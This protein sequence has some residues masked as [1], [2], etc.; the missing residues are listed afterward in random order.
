MITYPPG[1]TP[2]DP[3][4]E[5][6]LFVD[7]VTMAEL[8]EAEQ[9]NIL[10]G[11]RWALSSPRFAAQLLSERGLRELHKRMFGDVWR[12]AGSFRTRDLNL[13]VEWAR[14]AAQTKVLCDDAAYWLE[15]GTFSQPELAVRFHHRLVSIHPFVNGNGRHARLAAD[16][17]LFYRGYEM[18]PWG[19]ANLTKEGDV[20]RAYIKSLQVADAGDIEP[21]V[22]FAQ[23]GWARTERGGPTSRVDDE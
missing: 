15:H 12:W 20:R 7:V 17:L 9:E 18:L 10:A 13:G 1:A 14:V 5:E 16:L 6:E 8:N 11:L 19:K 2:L 21:L 3:A 4:W 22:A 23:T